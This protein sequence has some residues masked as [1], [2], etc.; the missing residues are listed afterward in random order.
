MDW[1]SVEDRPKFSRIRLFDQ[2]QIPDLILDVTFPSGL[3]PSLLR[4]ISRQMS[5]SIADHQ[6]RFRTSNR[7][8]EEQAVN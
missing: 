1:F 6:L 5:T 3:S 8:S 7:L 4:L 2:L